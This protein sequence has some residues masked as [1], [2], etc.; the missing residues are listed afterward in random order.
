MT[1][2][3]TTTEFLDIVRQSGVL[4]TGAFREYFQK[5]TDLPTEPSACASA[6]IKARLITPFQA[7]QF[8]AGKFRGLI[9]GQY[10]ILSQL[11]RGGMATVFLAEHR[12]LNRLVALKMFPP[13]KAKDQLAVERFKREARAAAAV[14]HPNIV[15]VFD[16]FAAMARQFIVMEYVQ[17]KDLHSLLMANGPLHFATAISY[18]LHAAKGLQ[19][20][21]EK[22]FIHRDIKPANLILSKDGTIKLLDMGLAR[23]FDP[24][25]QLTEQLDKDGAVGTADFCSPEQALGEAQDERSDIYS[26][27]AT[28]YALVTGVPPFKGNTTQVLSQHQFTAPPQIS[29]RLKAA[30]PPELDEVI[31]KMMAKKKTAR[32]QSVEEVIEAL[33]PFVSGISSGSSPETLSNSRGQKTKVMVDSQAVIPNWLRTNRLWVGAV[34]VVFAILLGVLMLSSDS[35]STPPVSPLTVSNNVPIAKVRPKEP[36]RVVVMKEYQAA[37]ASDGNMPSFRA[38][39]TEFLNSKVG[40]SRG[41]YL[42]QNWMVPRLE[43]IDQSENV[44]TAKGPGMS[45]TYQFAD[46]RLTVVVANNASQGLVC[47]LIF[48]STETTMIDALGEVHRLPFDGGKS[49]TP[50]ARWAKTTWFSG[51][52]KVTLNGAGCIWGPWEE[53]QVAEIS[54]PAGSSRTIVLEVGNPTSEELVKIGAVSPGETSQDLVIDQPKDYQVFQRQSRTLGKVAVRGRVG[55]T[56]SRVEARI[57]GNGPKGPLEGRWE[58]VKLDAART[59][60]ID[61]KAPAGGWYAV[62][63]RA[64]DDD[65]S[66]ASTTVGHVGIGEVFVIAGQSNSTNCGEERLKQTSGMVSTFS[67]KKWRLAD[68][69]QLGVKDGTTGG[70]PWPIFGDALYEQFHVPI[71]IA[72]TGYMGSSIAQWNPDSDLFRWMT[73]RMQQLD[74]HGFRAVLWHQG[75]ADVTM[76]TDEYARRLSELIQASRQTIGWEVPWFVAQASYHGPTNASYPSVREGQKKVWDLGLAFP[77]PDTDTLM[78]ENRDNGGRGIHFSGKGLRAHGA[79][80]AKKIRSYLDKILSE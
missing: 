50:E 61:L 44:I 36:D 65:Q 18:I 46:D 76:E 54:I 51:K 23:S 1:A 39:D 67:G 55:V 6:L 59:F 64:L 35:Q 31:G 17:G 78:G 72:S 25:D 68:D 19:H 9:L 10:K 66:V 53:H 11:G 4:D 22:G 43:D 63:V 2:P 15:R 74:N 37:I 30:T 12:G 52:T 47:F 79:A 34:G 41:L 38:R 33:N 14:D 28:L 21:H 29:K 60:S 73:Q 32:Y 69:P 5:D 45:I 77:G 20:A 16:V 58:S 7:R 49:G 48:D 56:A 71:G 27:G 75:E 8:L 13:A 26:L 42:W 70:S 57:S 62:D 40:I 3:T 80:W 24:R